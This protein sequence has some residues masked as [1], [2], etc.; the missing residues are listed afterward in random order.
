MGH[1][2]ATDCVNP[3]WRRLG[4]GTFDVG[5]PWETVFTGNDSGGGHSH[6]LLPVPGEANGSRLVN[7]NLVKKGTPP[8]YQGGY[9]GGYPMGGT[10][11]KPGDVLRFGVRTAEPAWTTVHNRDGEGD[12][13]RRF[14]GKICQQPQTRGSVLRDLWLDGCHP[15]SASGS[16]SRAPGLSIRKPFAADTR[17]LPAGVHSCPRTAR[18]TGR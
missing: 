9:L 11:G 2:P 4:F 8:D 12:K 10:T 3:E 17:P 13:D 14:V 7:R 16:L 1:P 18:S 5:H 6:T 15:V